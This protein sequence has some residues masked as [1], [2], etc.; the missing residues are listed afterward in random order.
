MSKYFISLLC[1]ITFGSGIA[2][3]QEPVQDSITRKYSYGLR[4]G[5]DLSRPT[6]S[7]L[8]DNYTG[9]E[10]V[11]DFRLTERW[12]LAAELGN[13]ERQQEETV[14]ALPLYTYTASGSYIKAGADYNTYTNWFG[15]RNQIHIGGRYAFSTFSQ[16][17]E[18]FRFY[19]SNRFFSPN[20][21]V[22]GEDTPR[23]ISGLSATWLEFVVGMKA[24]VFKNI[25]VGISARLA[26][27][28]TNS[29]DDNFKNLWI[30]GF[31]KVTENA[32]WGVGFNYTLSYYLPL[33]KKIK[34]K[35]EESAT[36]KN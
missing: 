4:V 13:E 8:K 7:F 25:Y 26:H 19:D 34:K 36:T 33:Y 28:V 17:V 18:N 11:G 31:N 20:E 32:K 35:K 24:E 9:L 23:E 6:L 30:P 3:K 22:L 2:Q 27:L 29:E 12:W 10:L 14:G 15:M 21:F 1:V 16:T 5:I